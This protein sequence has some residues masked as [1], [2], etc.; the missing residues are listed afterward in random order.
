MLSNRQKLILKAIIEA[1]VSDGVPVGSK[2]LTDK[3]YL[4]FSSATLRYDMAKLE[5]LGFLEKTHTSSGRIPSNMGYRYYVENLVT[6]DDEIK[7]I[8]PMIDQL[9]S[10]YENNRE[11][12]VKEAINLLSELTNYTSMVLGPNDMFARIKKVDFIPLTTS[13]A[14][15]LIVTDKGHV[16]SETVSIPDQL[17]LDDFKRIIA[18]LNDLLE[19]QLVKDAKRILKN[20]YTEENIIEYM[21]YQERL[22]DTFVNAFKHMADQNVYLTGMG[23][24][25][26]Q[27]E[28]QDVNQIKELMYMLDRKELVKLIGHTNKLS[29]KIGREASFMPTDTCTIISVPYYVSDEDQGTIAIIGPTRMDYSKVIPLMEYVAKNIA[30]LYKK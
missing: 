26:L 12:A 9:F 5:E 15:V 8:F 10:E 17:S 6:R 27:P 23:Q 19:N 7:Q 2:A 30:K 11:Y 25:L 1:Y 13:E 14:V 20:A 24:M 16:Q 4:N 21:D 3:P 18:S 28:F 22:V 29:I